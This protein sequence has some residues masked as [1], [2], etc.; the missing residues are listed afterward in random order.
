M[1]KAKDFAGMMG[2]TPRPKASNKLD[3][4]MQGGGSPTQMTQ[5]VDMMR[6]QIVS[7]LEKRGVF[8]QVKNDQ[9]MDEIMALVDELVEA[10]A[11]GDQQAVMQNP[12][13]ELLGGAA[14]Q[15]GMM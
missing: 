13:M 4:R 15:E 7:E 2:A 10:M 11:A 6:E 3:E 14:P 8:N 5:Q 12:L 1:A 9:D